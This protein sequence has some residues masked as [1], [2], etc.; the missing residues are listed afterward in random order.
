MRRNQGHEMLFPQTEALWVVLRSEDKAQ[1]S[2][3][4]NSGRRREGDQVRFKELHLSRGSCSKAV[5]YFSARS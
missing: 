5:I 3:D 2:C 4:R 1:D